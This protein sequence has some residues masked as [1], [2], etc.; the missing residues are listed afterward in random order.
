MTAD[1]FVDQY[2]LD[3]H[4]RQTA[5]TDLYQAWDVDENMAVM[6][7]I[8]LPSASKQYREEF[9]EKMR[10][11]ATLKHPHIAEIYQVGIT[12]QARPY[13]AHEYIE[14]YTL[15]DRMNQLIA[16]G[17]PTN[18]LYALQIITQLAEALTTAE[19]RG[20]FHRHLSPENIVLKNDGT[21]ILVDLG[22]P[23]APL[24]ESEK[25][26]FVSE[27]LAPEQRQGKMIDGRSHVYSL[28]VIL[29]ELLTGSLPL[30]ADSIW[31]SIRRKSSVLE[32]SRPDL[33]PRIYALINRSLRKEPWRR[34]ASLADFS[35]A[36]HEALNAQKLF[37][38]TGAEILSAPLA[39][40]SQPWKFLLLPVAIVI[41]IIALGFTAVWIRNSTVP[42]KET[43]VA[44]IASETRQAPPTA[45][46]QV[47]ASSS[48]AAANNIKILEP[49]A[50]AAYNIGATVVFSWTTSTKLSE[51]QQYSV[52]II[53]QE[54]NEIPVGAIT[55]NDKDG[56]YELE[57]AMTFAQEPG[58]YTWHV[59]L[60]NSQTKERLFESPLSSFTIVETPT[61]THTATMTATPRPT[62]TATA[63]PPTETPLPP[64]A[65]PVPPT[66]TSIPPT[67]TPIPPTATPIPP[68]A[69]PVPPTPV[70]PTQPPPAPTQPPAPP[71]TNT[72]PPPPP[73]P[74]RT[75]PPP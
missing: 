47:P 26:V 3:A 61:P 32:T 10:Q 23:T 21:V 50:K 30:A 15:R 22:Y 35:Q 74:T 27:Y 5:V 11:T 62:D 16:R 57:T 2:R 7:E 63:I 20:L 18:S 38:Q 44:A 68:T 49:P 31:Q 34:Y 67:S 29:Y 71:P 60:E 1:H 8:L 40:S 42:P 66:A 36:I 48:L 56:T 75:P 43:A 45:T 41:F 13:A 53:D 37:V 58:L 70:P 69:T 64:T 19:K 28:G 54:G 6:V 9:L 55:Q 72:P 59:I 51:N 46:P 17:A 65:T 33:E 39:Q 14:G 73:A 24:N 52:Y 12:P 4:V 25:D